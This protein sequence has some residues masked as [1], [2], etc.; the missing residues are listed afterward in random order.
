MK[1]WGGRPSTDD[2]RESLCHDQVANTLTGERPAVSG[3]G[4]PDAH[5][6]RSCSSG[7]TCP[8]LF[9]PP[10]D[11]GPLRSGDAGGSAR[12]GMVEHQHSEAVLYGDHGDADGFEGEGVVLG[13]SA[14]LFGGRHSR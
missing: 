4:T 10:C 5:S 9:R 14:V 3:V 7:P 2:P 1:W 6:P 12:T 11:G 8:P 13:S